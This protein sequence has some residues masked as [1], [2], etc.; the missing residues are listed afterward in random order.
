MKNFTLILFFSLLTT[1]FLSANCDTA[2][3]AA[4][5]AVAHTKRALNA[6]NFDHQKYYAER[7]LEAFEKAEGLITNCGCNKALNPIIDGIDQ[8]KSAIDPEDWDMG[9][10]HTKRAFGYAQDVLTTMDVC[11]GNNNAPNNSV[12][13]DLIENIVDQNLTEEQKRLA[14]EQKKLLKQQQILEQKIEE[15]KILAEQAK[16]NRQIELEEQLRLKRVAEQSLDDLERKIKELAIIYGCD[17][18]QSLINGYKSRKDEVL[19][20]E[21]LEETKNYYLQQTISLQ[22]KAMEM[23]KKCVSNPSK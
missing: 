14:E 5:Y 11:S 2:Y 16:V 4:T 10:Y 8:L 22:A 6:D 12:D 1:S 23:F 21:T 17:N 3:S 18:T 13:P 9:R 7:A 19:N 15:Q 20:N